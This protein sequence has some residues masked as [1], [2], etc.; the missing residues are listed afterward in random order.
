MPLIRINSLSLAETKMKHPQDF[1]LCV[2]DKSGTV[3]FGWLPLQL[4]TAANDPEIAWELLRKMASLFENADVIE[5]RHCLS[6]N[7]GSD[8]IESRFDEF[9]DTIGETIDAIRTRA[10]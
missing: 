2:L 10:G 8:E 7:L 3:Y 9:V 1:T 5:A 4:D 6:R